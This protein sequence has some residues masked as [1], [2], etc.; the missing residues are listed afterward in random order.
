MARVMKFDSI[1]S[2]AY[3]KAV[4]ALVW[5]TAP[6]KVVA[7][8]VGIMLVT[9]LLAPLSL[10]LLKLTVNAIHAAMT[11]GGGPSL[12]RAVLMLLLAALVALLDLL[13]G[14]I[15]R[16]LR[17]RQTLITVD[18]VNERLQEKSVQ[19]DLSFFESSAYFDKLHRAQTESGSRLGR[20]LDDMVEL[21]FNL[22][23][24]VA[25]TCLILSTSWSVTLVLVAAAIPSVL[26]SL[27]HSRLLYDWMNATTTLKR[28]AGYLYALLTGEHYAKEL[29]LYGLGGLFMAR[30]RDLTELLRNERLKVDRKRAWAGFGTQ[31]IAIVAGYLAFGIL[32]F[33][34]VRGT[35]TVGDLF[36]YFQALRRVQGNLSSVMGTA[37]EFYENL[38]FLRNLFEFLSLTPEVSEPLEPLPVPRPMQQGIRFDRVS[39][40]YGERPPVLRDISL[41]ILPGQVVALVGANGAGKT[42]LVKL[43]CRLHDPGGGRITLDGTDLRDLAMSDLRRQFSFVFQDFVQYQASARDNI[44]YGEI[45]GSAE[46][47]T[48]V[49]AA[50]KAGA[51]D[52]LRRLPK[53][54]DSILG[55]WFDDGRQLSQGEWQKV[56][57]ARALMRDSQI[58]VLDEPTSSLDVEAE[59]A[60]YTGFRQ[61]LGGRSAVI[62][63]HRFS[64]V[65][66]AD[67]IYVLDG[68]TI[69]EE[70][71]HD[72]LMSRQG[73]YAGMYR[74]HARQYSRGDHAL[75]PA[76]S[77][78]PI[79]DQL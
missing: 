72:E 36:L 49:A 41:R 59:E 17:S 48:I 29:R 60:F 57:L 45:T 37:S 50:R 42:T 77:Q 20:V 12:R 27:K 38:L 66:M 68:C 28:R 40:S 46:D 24:L 23:T 52:L 22:A 70:G 33:A 32:A 35:A 18:R 19:L 65:R 3:V 76:K 69:G 5:E 67:Y 30:H 51:Y 62:V 78:G 26:I 8:A 56:A 13:F 73:V 71:T 39:F 2:F 7:A 4:L 74:A 6:R 16:L 44:W 25:V 63:S 58:I 34:A 47:A 10:Y 79:G 1:R 43:L 15:L 53:G 54:F 64:S 31:S 11:Q 55:S 21:F 75:Q 61:N 14:V 9:S